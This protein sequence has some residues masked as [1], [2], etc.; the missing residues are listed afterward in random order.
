MPRAVFALCAFG[1][2]IMPSSANAL[3]PGALA[4]TLEDAELTDIF[5]LDPDTG[6]AVGDRGVIWHTDDA[7]RK[8]RLQSSPVNCRL[9]SV[10]FVDH[11]RGWA[12]GGW[13]APFT[14][15]SHGVV[16][17]TLDGGKHWTHAGGVILPWV[18]QVRFTDA[19]NGWALG[20]SS[21]L[22]SSGI[23]HTSDGGRSWAALPGAAPSGWQAGDLINPKHGIVAGSFG[24][25][26]AVSGGVIHMVRKETEPL[27]PDICQVVTDGERRGWVVG[28]NGLALVTDDLGN[29]WNEVPIALPTRVLRQM[30][31]QTVAIH[32]NHVWIAG[33]PGTFVMHSSDGGATWNQLST[34]QNLPLRRLRF[35]DELR[36]FAVGALGTIL[37]TRDGGHTWTVQRS[38]GQ[39]AAVFIALADAQAA[40]L[41]SLAHLCA[42]E[43]HLGVAHIVSRADSPLD[44][45]VTGSDD[46]ARESLTQV[47]VAVV[48]TQWQFPMRTDG[49]RL[50]GAA[51]V[52]SW[53]K[54]IG[55][56]AVDQ[57][58]ESLV[59]SLRTW[60]PDIVI[61]HSAL[62]S[63]D[64][65]VGYL[66]NQVVQ[67]AVRKAGDRH[68]YSEHAATL[69]LRPW[70][71]QKLYTFR[72][73]DDDASG[74]S[75]LVVY[76]SQIAPRLSQ[77][78]DEFAAY[79]RSLLSDA[80]AP[81]PESTGFRRLMSADSVLSGGRDFFSG[82][83][84]SSSVA[85]R[86]RQTAA[87][88][89]DIHDLT[90]RAQLQRNL[91]H[92]IARTAAAGDGNLSLLAQ[93]HPLTR[94][95]P[96]NARGNALFELAEQLRK[97]GRWDEAT[98]LY[99]QLLHHYTAHPYTEAAIYRL[100]QTLCSAELTWLHNSNL[101]IRLDENP[102]QQCSPMAKLQAD[103]LRNHAPVIHDPRIRF[104][105]AAMYRQA[106]ES[107]QALVSYRRVY[108][109]ERLSGW[110]QAARREL[111]MAEGS[112]TPPRGFWK[113]QR[114]TERPFLDGQFGDAV[115]QKAEAVELT[116][117]LDDD[118]Q[119][120]AAMKIAY[121][122]EFVYLAITCRN[123]PHVAYAAAHQSRGRDADLSDSDRV[124]IFLDVDR[125]YAT[126]YQLQVDSR[127]LVYEDCCGDPSWN[128]TW[129]VSSDATASFWSVEAAI[130]FSAL[131]EQPPKS[132]DAWCIGVQ[133]IVPGSGFQSWT[134]P[135]STR[136]KHD[137][138]GCLLFE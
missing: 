85:S 62:P 125:D 37:A 71:V 109:Q 10:F 50:D 131:V 69:K 126:S 31:F 111:W 134:Q 106:H 23:F 137:G 102:L 15:T 56:K 1:L 121:D 138:F 24:R 18:K 55:G 74:T 67:N 108:H 20:H 112:G 83:E 130:P 70:K 118:T 66:L 82:I 63:D 123:A 36:G 9:E 43:G 22:H 14:H 19:R 54:Q 84:N 98:E 25:L 127:G 7:G 47:G 95:L 107:Q 96:D 34:G 116:S 117:A 99:Q 120:P 4:E 48:E 8:W 103:I 49:M 128:P 38:G 86:R 30:D 5:F 33:S 133:R 101:T 6:W 88:V 64:Q 122:D 39:R 46:R 104:P 119:W 61:T 21:P 113:C 3:P 114:A 124:Q 41:E 51:I 79:S 90:R 89:G 87:G 100:T 40:P 12:V 65:P 44:L 115:W 94:D 52:E 27:L 80:F 29:T 28:R 136:G 92:L 53:D 57:L 105:F 135:A 59:R 26:A 42:D 73:E 17:R 2:L 129:Y 75:P 35:L 91:R 16:L 60:Q 110:G 97:L 45:N 77:S 93:L 32:Q 132:R 13:T 68:L 81:G 78:L 72:S 58:E 11:R 76:S